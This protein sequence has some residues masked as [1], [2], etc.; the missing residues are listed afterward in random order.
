MIGVLKILNLS[1]IL[2][3][4]LVDRLCICQLQLAA[5]NLVE[6]SGP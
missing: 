5:T 4:Y 2:S 1:E 3:V 6:F